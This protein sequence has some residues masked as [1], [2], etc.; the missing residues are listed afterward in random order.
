M[1]YAVLKV[2]AQK[3]IA[4]DCLRLALF[5]EVT[6]LI[7]FMHYLRAAQSNSRSNA[8]PYTTLLGEI[9]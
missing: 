9:R 3:L 1:V 8:L 2:E 5:I 4:K 6:T 7:R